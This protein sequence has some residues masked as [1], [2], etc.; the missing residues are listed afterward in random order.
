[1]VHR[2]PIPA[3]LFGFLFAVVA[4]LP[5]LAQSDRGAISG[6][7]ID[8]NGGAVR[9]AKVTVVNL[10]SGASREVATTDDGAF[11]VPELR[12]APYRLTVEAAGF[13]TMTL[14]R[15]QIAVQVTRRVD[16]RLEVGALGEVT[17]V[18]A[19]AGALQTEGPV[20]QT[21]ITERQV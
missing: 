18:T 19:A 13:K 10:D 2:M 21:N 5:A 12:A 11:V 9:R 8:Q 20:L 14:D 6:T 15:L 3:K 1:M 7:V 16:V 4:S 17:T